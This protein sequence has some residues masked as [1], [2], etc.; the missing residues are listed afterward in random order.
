MNV[1]SDCHNLQATHGRYHSLYP[2]RMGEEYDQITAIIREQG[3]SHE[4]QCAVL[5]MRGKS[6]YACVHVWLPNRNCNERA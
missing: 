1:F 5:S 6:R 3:Q 4:C 2:C